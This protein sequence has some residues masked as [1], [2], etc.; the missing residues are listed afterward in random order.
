MFD[1]TGAWFSVDFNYYTVKPTHYT[2]SHPGDDG[3]NALR[4]WSLQAQD[5]SGAWQTLLE[6]KNECVLELT[7]ESR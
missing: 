2:L 3:K 7:T 1:R 4:N 5:A 6:H